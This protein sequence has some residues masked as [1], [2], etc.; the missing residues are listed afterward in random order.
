MGAGITDIAIV[1]RE[2]EKSIIEYFSP[3]PELDA[4]LEK[5]GKSQ[6]LA[7]LKNIMDNVKFTFFEQTDK[8][9]YGNGSP[10]LV[11]KDFIGQDNFF[12]CWGDDMTIE[13]TPGGF[14]KGMLD[15]WQSGDIDA[16]I[17]TFVV[18]WEFVSQGGT[19]DYIKNP[20]YPNQIKA[21]PEKLPPDK[22]PSN[23][24][25]ASRFIVSPSIIPVLENLEIDRG[26]LWFTNAVS[27]FAKDHV[28]VTADYAD[29]NSS[30]V[31]T[32]DPENWFKA[33]LL[34]AQ[35]NP[36]YSSILNSFLPQNK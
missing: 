14:L 27:Q 1:V 18:P 20:K 29:F 5:T 2:G 34:W 28:V 24:Y 25:N 19:M 26:E 36:K 17:A 9:P 33:N 4:Y 22:A 8:F 21:I 15:I 30:W 7:S 16:V 3:N 13:D 6:R 11:A 10:I 32:G 23:H 35:K 12:Y 31:T